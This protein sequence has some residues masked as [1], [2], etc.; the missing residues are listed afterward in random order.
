MKDKSKIEGAAINYANNCSTGKTNYLTKLTFEHGATSE[1][2]QEYWTEGVY[3]EEHILNSISKVYGHMGFTSLSCLLM[4]EI[5]GKEEY[6]H[7][8]L[9]KLYTEEEINKRM[10]IFDEAL[11]ATKDHN[12]VMGYA[13]L[14][15]LYKTKTNEQG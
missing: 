8:E 13:E 9:P 2:A 1:A 10:E 3:T 12:V 7:R 5:T 11:A 14:F 4:K 15:N 6:S